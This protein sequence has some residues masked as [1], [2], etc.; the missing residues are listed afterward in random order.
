MQK[1]SGLSAKDLF[2]WNYKPNL[3]LTQ[4]L[5]LKYLIYKRGK[6]I[7]V[8]YLTKNKEFYGRDFYV[9]KN[10]LIPR[11]ETEQIIDIAKS[12]AYS[13][14]SIL[15]IGTGSG[16]IA[17]TLL[18]ETN[19]SKAI[20]IDISSQ[21]LS[22]A[23]KNSKVHGTYH[24]SFFVKSDLLDKVPKRSTFDLIV[25]N[26]PYIP[27]ND[28][29]LVSPETKKYEPHL[30]LFSGED[31]LDCFRKIFKQIKLK[32]IQ[33]KYIIGEFGFGQRESIELLLQQ[34]FEGCQYQIF[35]D[36]QG[37]PRIFLLTNKSWN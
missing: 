18:K 16:C 12:L 30:A 23:K 3:S 36:L 15:D 14:N 13:P 2:M 5:H 11:P 27:Q 37:I 35:D 1:V 4:R 25:T 8:A 10:V 22:I 34:N 33:Y 20:L 26:P 19:A 31:G 24:K 9:D 17:T 28:P 29:K 32:D 6:G 21:A 7:P